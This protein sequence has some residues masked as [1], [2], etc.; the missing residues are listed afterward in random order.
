[1][2]TQSQRV[3]PGEYEEGFL[4][5]NTWIRPVAIFVLICFGLLA[6]II[7]AN[8]TMGWLGGRFGQ[9]LFGMVAS[10]IF[11]SAVISVVLLIVNGARYLLNS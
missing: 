3:D 9:V 8:A 5:Q 7:T 1:M 2:S 6:L 4:D 11:M 10:L